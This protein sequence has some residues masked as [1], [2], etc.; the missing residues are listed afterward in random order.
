MKGVL[1]DCWEAH[2]TGEA[3]NAD[4]QM[5]MRGR[6]AITRIAEKIMK[7]VPVLGRTIK[8]KGGVVTD[9]FYRTGRRWRRVDVKG[10]RVTAHGSPVC[11]SASLNT[12]SSRRPVRPLWTQLSDC[13]GLKGGG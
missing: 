6:K 7:A 13:A 8:A 11:G 12:R 5:R 9:E 2:Q 4:G 3:Y 1:E 10:T